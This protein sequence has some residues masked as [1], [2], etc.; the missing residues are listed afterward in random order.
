GARQ[1]IGF[2]VLGQCDAGRSTLMP[3]CGLLDEIEFGPRCRDYLA[4]HWS[5]NLLRRAPHVVVTR[6]PI[7]AIGIGF[8]EPVNAI[9]TA[10]F[11]AFMLAHFGSYPFAENFF[12]HHL[13]CAHLCSPST[14]ALEPHGIFI[15]PGSPPS[16]ASCRTNTPSA[17]SVRIAS[18]SGT[19]PW[20]RAKTSG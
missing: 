5:G 4:C 14:H 7:A 8:L 10:S 15:G 17:S 3:R 2:T 16:V 1:V 12:R 19:C 18:S 20:M 9:Y 11:A 6:R 13:P